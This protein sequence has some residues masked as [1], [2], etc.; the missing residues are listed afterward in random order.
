[1]KIIFTI[2]LAGIV[3][4]LHAQDISRTINDGNTAYKKG[5]YKTASE[6]YKKALDKNGDNIPARFNLGNALDKQHDV[7]SAQKYYDDVS[8]STNDASLKSKAFY[9]KGVALVQQQKLPEA[10]DAFK[11]ALKLTP[12]DD[13]VRENLQKAINDLKRQ[14]QSRSPQQQKNKPKQQQQQ[15]NKQVNPQVM[16]QKFNELR[17]KEKQLQKMLQQKPNQA[18]PDKDW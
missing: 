14:Q 12:E 8:T 11:Q 5:D 9:N 3:G 6:L 7:L 17:D 15:Q 16:E 10:I 2:F 4:V 13:E 18:Q 1:L